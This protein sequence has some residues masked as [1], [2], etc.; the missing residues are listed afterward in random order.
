MKIRRLINMKYNYNFC[1]CKK[2]LLIDI[3]SLDSVT[4]SLE[5]AIEEART[6]PVNLSVFPTVM[7]LKIDK[8][9]EMVYP[10]EL[11]ESNKTHNFTLKRIKDLS[12]KRLEELY[13]KEDLFRM[14]EEGKLESLVCTAAYL[15][16]SEDY[17][18]I[19]WSAD[20]IYSYL[21]N[22]LTPATKSLAEHGFDF[23][24]Y[25][26]KVSEFAS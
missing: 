16:D 11:N 20:E 8:K 3:R 1:F 6:L 15:A 4:S 14:I 25:S 10:L 17:E 18:E 12:M 22:N 26:Y 19:N 9:R 2:D 7:K 21:S 23:R 5:D 13:S 24:C